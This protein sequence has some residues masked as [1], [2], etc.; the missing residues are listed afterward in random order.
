M[1]ADFD[2]ILLA[3]RNGNRPVPLIAGRAAG[4]RGLCVQRI[5]FQDSAHITGV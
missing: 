1:K 4:D 3:Q 5:H 2:G